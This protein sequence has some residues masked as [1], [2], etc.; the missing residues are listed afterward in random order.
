MVRVRLRCGCGLFVVLGFVGFVGVGG[1]G[2][3]AL[4]MFLMCVARSV[5]SS[6]CVDSVRVCSPT[7]TGA[8]A[9]GTGGGARV[10]VVWS[11]VSWVRESMVMLV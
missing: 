4:R 5:V 11:R 1:F 3:D 6:C 9:V 7:L 10:G 2:N 8:G